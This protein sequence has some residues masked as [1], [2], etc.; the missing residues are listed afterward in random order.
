MRRA[1]G[2]LARG[3]NAGLNLSSRIASSMPGGA[4]KDERNCL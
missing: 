2:S 4:A 3:A 1:H